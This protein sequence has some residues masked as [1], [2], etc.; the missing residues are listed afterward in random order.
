MLDIKKTIRN[1]TFI[2]LICILVITFFEVAPIIERQFVTRYFIVTFD[3]GTGNDFELLVDE[4]KPV[5]KPEQPVREGYTFV[6]WYYKND[7]YNF[8]TH[9]RKDITLKA[10]WEKIKEPEPEEKEKNKFI[11]KFDVSGGSLIA[12]QEVIKGGTATIPNPPTREGYTF[13]EWQ[14]DGNTY[15]FGTIIQDDITIIAIWKENT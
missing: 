13:V 11:V 3:T 6:G 15:D 14:L 5:I 9:I 1:T 12:D 4:D 2:L 8:N 7:E 10:K